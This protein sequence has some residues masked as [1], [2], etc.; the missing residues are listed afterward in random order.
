MLTSHF[1]SRL[2]I[3]ASNSV[4]NKIIVQ[5]W[6]SAY[7]EPLNSVAWDSC[8][9]QWEVNS[10]FQLQ[11]TAYDDHSLAYSMLT[12]ESSIFFQGEEW[13]VKT[14]QPDYSGMV[15]TNQVTAT[16]AYFDMSR[17]HQWQTK[18]GT[19]SYSPNDVLAYWLNDNSLG[20]TYEIKGIFTNQPI[21]NLGNGSGTD[22][23]SKIIETWPTAV[24]FP[25][26]RQI[27]V[28]SADEWAQDLGNRINYIHDTTEIQMS[29]DSTS[30]FNET[31]VYGATKD[32]D[33]NS[34]TDSDTTSYYFEPYIVKDEASIAKWG[35]RP[36]ADIS[37]DRFTDKNSMDVYARTQLVTEPQL[38]ISITMN[39]NTKPVPGEIRRTEIRNAGYSSN[40]QVV[41][42]QWYP[43]S[44]GTQTTITLNT[45]AK[46]ILDLQNSESKMIAKAV[47]NSKQNSQLAI[48]AQNTATKAYNSRIY[49][50][51]VGDSDY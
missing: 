5:G 15:N 23:I 7:R 41:G 48:T 9:I 26:G 46:S 1:H 12:N 3:L 44:P 49:G 17:V 43:N 4:N 28:Y 40:L 45:S 24:V 21:E 11:F 19:F 16:H 29:P 14:L 13:I 27:V 2:F 8:S 35:E 51:K 34:D 31:M 25:H 38:S 30:L 20:Y 33:T 10:T 37:D 39:D 42:Y 32:T 50:E 22:M 6:G 47:K 18:T 36:G